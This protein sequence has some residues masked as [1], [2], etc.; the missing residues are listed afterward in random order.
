MEESI[1]SLFFKEE[2]YLFADLR[3]AKNKWV[4]KLQNPQRAKI[5]GPQIANPQN[6]TLAEGL[7][8]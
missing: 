2:N 6:A 1:L 3:T 5:D 8:I 7:Q 4:R